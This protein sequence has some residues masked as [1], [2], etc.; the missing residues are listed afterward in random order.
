MPLV[1]DLRKISCQ[2]EAHTLAR[3]FR[4]I[5][6]AV[7]SFEEGA[8]GDA[9]HARDHIEAASRDPVDAA[10]VLMRLLIGDADEIGEL[11]LSE[12][13]HDAAVADARTD[14]PVDVLRLYCGLYAR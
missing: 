4:P 1:G 6:L 10:L 9:Q 12:A 14:V 8:H 3:A 2:F 5:R 13:E 7:E 11:L